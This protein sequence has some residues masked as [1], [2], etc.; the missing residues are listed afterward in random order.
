MF[1]ATTSLLVPSTLILLGQGKEQPGRIPRFLTL[2]LAGEQSH[3]PHTDSP[4]LSV[5]LAEAVGGQDWS[6]EAHTAQ[7]AD[8]S[9]PSWG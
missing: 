1:A 9:L 5:R 7:K 2:P 6:E 4:G 8:L 3:S